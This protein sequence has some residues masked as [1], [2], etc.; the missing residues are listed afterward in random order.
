MGVLIEEAA[1][2][3]LGDCGDMVLVEPEGFDQQLPE[4]R[5]SQTQIRGHVP[6]AIT[7]PEIIQESS[8]SES[9]EDPTPRKKRARYT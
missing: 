5:E 6:R 9:A 2:Q 4:S 3:I 1:T 7:P 8:S